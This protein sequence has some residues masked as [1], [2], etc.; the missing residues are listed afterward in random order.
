MAGSLAERLLADVL[1]NP[2][3]EP[4]R[5]TLRQLRRML[6]IPEPE[7]RERL[8]HIYVVSASPLAR[9]LAGTLK[10]LVAETFSGA[11]VQYG[12]TDGGS[13][14]D[15]DFSAPTADPQVDRPGR[16]RALHDGCRAAT[17]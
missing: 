5:K 9:D 8:E 4:E 2:A 15:R 17:F 13:L 1:W 12:G 6:V 3:L 10:G 16:A 14:I 11:P 7:M